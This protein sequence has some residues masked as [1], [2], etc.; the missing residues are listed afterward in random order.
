MF[1][2]DVE[3][4]ILCTFRKPIGGLMEAALQFLGQNQQAFLIKEVRPE[5]KT[6]QLMSKESFQS[7]Y[8]YY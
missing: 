8:K 5:A 2:Y 3:F 7:G 1:R 6:R 4:N